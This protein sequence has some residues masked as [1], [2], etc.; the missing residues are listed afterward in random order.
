LHHQQSLPK[1]RFWDLKSVIAVAAATHICTDPYA[2]DDAHA[3]IELQQ[4]TI[5]LISPQLKVRDRWAPMGDLSSYLRLLP[6]LQIAN[7]APKVLLLMFQMV[8][9]FFLFSSAFMPHSE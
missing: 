6:S 5:L 1:D 2:D 9:F 4:C 3:K 7:F 8:L